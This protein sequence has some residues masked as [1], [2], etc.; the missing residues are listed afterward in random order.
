MLGVQT[1]LQLLVDV[2]VGCYSDAMKTYPTEGLNGLEEKSTSWEPLKK[3]HV[4]SFFHSLLYVIILIVFH[5]FMLI[6]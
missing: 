3:T 6:A 2:Q 5:I 4:S 1:S